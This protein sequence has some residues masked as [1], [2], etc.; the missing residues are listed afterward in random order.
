MQQAL[1]VGGLHRGE[2]G[3]YGRAGLFHGQPDAAE[4]LRERPPGEV[5]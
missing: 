3:E 1:V 5:F 4:T 2:N